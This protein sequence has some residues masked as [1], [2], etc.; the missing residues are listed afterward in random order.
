VVNKR[1]I[2]WTMPCERARALALDAK[3]QMKIN[4]PPENPPRGG[5]VVL[6]NGAA[7]EGRPYKTSTQ[8]S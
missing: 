7:T 8:S 4:G 6:E 3:A 1:A 5:V 2:G